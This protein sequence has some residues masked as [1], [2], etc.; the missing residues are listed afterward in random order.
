[1]Y[2]V[3]EAVFRSASS[4]VLF[5][6][7]ITNEYENPLL[8]LPFWGHICLEKTEVRSHPGIICIYFQQLRL[9]GRPC[10]RLITRG[11]MRINRTNV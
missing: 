4:G 6:L 10:R 1:M 8:L 2:Q 9:N 7:V 11:V 5:S 3:P